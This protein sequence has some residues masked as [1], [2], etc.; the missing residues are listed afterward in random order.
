[1]DRD[2]QYFRAVLFN[3]FYALDKMVFRGDESRR[4]AAFVILC[5]AVCVG[6]CVS[7]SVN[8]A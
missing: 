1:M 8:A 2:E 3:C 4:A 5:S 7:M 6:T